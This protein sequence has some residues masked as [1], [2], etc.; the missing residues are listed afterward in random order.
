MPLASAGRSD[1]YGPTGARLAGCAANA[2]RQKVGPNDTAAAVVRPDWINRR[3]VSMRHV[4]RAVHQR[5]KER[6]SG[7]NGS[8]RF[9]AIRSRRHSGD[10]PTTATGAP[11]APPDR[12]R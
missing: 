2:V 10:G 12:L 6:S 3:R 8:C 7:V 1:P 11:G 4:Y 9:A 5:A